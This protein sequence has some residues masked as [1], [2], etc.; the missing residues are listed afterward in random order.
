MA[1]AELER[2]FLARLVNEFELEK[3]WLDS[4]AALNQEIWSRIFI[5]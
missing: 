5:F 2:K 1:R 4:F 3:A